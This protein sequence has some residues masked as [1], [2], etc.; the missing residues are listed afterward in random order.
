MIGKES[1]KHWFALYTRP[2]HEFKA[3]KQITSLKVENFLPAIKK[4]RKWADRIKSITEPLISGYIFIFANENERLAAVTSDAVVNTVSF[5]G[6]PAIIPDWQIESLKNMLGHSDEIEVKITDEFPVG[7]RVKVVSWP[8]EGI[9][10]VVEKKLNNENYI[11]I[12]LEFVNRMI[13]VR[14]PADAVTKIVE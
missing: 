14:L 3:R 9:I 13:S 8:M 5:K 1:A 10:G 7:T 2:K 6:I 11:C 4:R 12:S